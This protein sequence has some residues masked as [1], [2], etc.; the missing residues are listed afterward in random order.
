MCAMLEISEFSEENS[1][2]I[3][4]YVLEPKEVGDNLS[5]SN[6]DENNTFS[7]DNDVNNEMKPPVS[8][9]VLKSYKASWKFKCQVCE[10]TFGQQFQLTYHIRRHHFNLQGKTPYCELKRINQ[11]W[12]ENVLNSNNIMEIKKTGHNTLVMRKLDTNTGIK[13]SDTNTE[14]IDL[15]TVYPIHNRSRIKVQCHICKKMY[16]KITIKKHMD[17]KHSDVHRH[18]C[19]NCNRTFKRSYFFLRHVCNREPRARGRKPIM[20]E[21]VQSLTSIKIT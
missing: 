18:E 16:L 13:V 20:I 19:N 8:V 14:T 21:K 6:K 3:K 10:K 11:V 12:F 5:Y 7:V 15:S 4:N 17:E 1:S 2:L 9:K